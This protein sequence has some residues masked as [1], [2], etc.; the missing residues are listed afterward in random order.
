MIFIIIELLLFFITEIYK[1]YQ[2]LYLT[3]NIYISKKDY[4]ISTKRFIISTKQFKKTQKKNYKR[5][6]YNMI[7]VIYLKQK[8]LEKDKLQLRK[9]NL[10][11]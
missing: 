1:T 4:A 9:T 3:V 8:D 6:R 11:S 2:D 5:Y 7:K 10:F